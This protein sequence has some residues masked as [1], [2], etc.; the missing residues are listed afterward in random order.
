MQMWIQ[1]VWCFHGKLSAH[2]WTEC[3]SVFALFTQQSLDISSEYLQFY[4]CVY[5]YFFQYL[6]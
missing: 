2:F 4:I 1:A 6:I 5:K 3:N